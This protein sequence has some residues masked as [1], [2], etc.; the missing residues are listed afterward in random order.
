[1]TSV[2]YFDRKPEKVGFLRGILRKDWIL[3]QDN[4]IQLVDIYESKYRKDVLIYCKK[5]SI[6]KN[7]IEVSRNIFLPKYKTYKIYKCKRCLNDKR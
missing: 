1:M 7:N 4:L 2:E 6:D 3:E 5:N